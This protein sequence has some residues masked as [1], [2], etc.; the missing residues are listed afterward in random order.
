MMEGNFLRAQFLLKSLS[1]GLT[2]AHQDSTRISI[3]CSDSSPSL[4]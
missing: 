2:V 4:K 1:H 3:R